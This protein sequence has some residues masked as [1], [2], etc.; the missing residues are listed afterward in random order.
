MKLSKYFS[1][2]A[3]IATL[4]T[5]CDSSTAPEPTFERSADVVTTKEARVVQTNNHGAD[6]AYVLITPLGGTITAGRHSLKVPAGAVS[7]PTWFLM[8]VVE[9]KAIHVK[10]QAWRAADFAP[11]TQFPTV[12]VE[13]TLNVSDV[14]P[15]DLPSLVVAYLRDETYD[16]RKEVQPTNVDVQNK[17]VTGY[18]T[19]FSSYVVAKEIIIGIN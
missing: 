15:L 18:L 6:R 10:L 7:S 4:L 12:P 13:L 9:S 5:A 8:K 3:V 14:S 16:G 1:A 17:V 19:H 11:V 2:V